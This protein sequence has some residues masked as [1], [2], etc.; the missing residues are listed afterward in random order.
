[1]RS[2]ARERSRAPARPHAPATARSPG[3]RPPPGATRAPRPRPRSPRT[4]EPPRPSRASRRAHEHARPRA[5]GQ[6]EE[7]ADDDG[8]RADAPVERD[9]HE[10]RPESEPQHDPARREPHEH[11]G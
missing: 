6:Q 10:V 3:S 11:P 4:P 8:R 1:P 2:P 7:T 9:A 5:P